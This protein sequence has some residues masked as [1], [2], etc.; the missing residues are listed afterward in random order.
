MLLVFANQ[1]I[2]H[3]VRNEMV[4]SIVRVS[5][6]TQKSG[7]KQLPTNLPEAVPHPLGP[8]DHRK[9]G[10]PHLYRSWL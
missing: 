4:E 10:H 7:L 9:V 1:K 2:V 5:Q 3:K 8:Y 6:T